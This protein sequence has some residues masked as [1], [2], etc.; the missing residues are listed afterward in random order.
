[1]S[2][3][4]AVRRGPARLAADLA[5]TLLTGRPGP[6]PR[7]GRKYGE[8]GITFKG[9]VGLELTARGLDVQLE[10]YTDEDF[11]DARAGIIATA[12]AT[13]ADARICVTDDGCLT[14]TREHWPQAAASTTDPEFYGS[15]T[16]PAAVAAAVVDE[17]NRAMSLLRSSGQAEP[18]PSP[19]GAAT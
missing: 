1:M 5:T 8:E 18:G 15:I 2:G 11:F 3:R 6:Y 19:A 16:N 9:L 10:V 4:G 14:W 12:P 7:L 17:A 13:S